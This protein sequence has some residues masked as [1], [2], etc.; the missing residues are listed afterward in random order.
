MILESSAVFMER[1][2]EKNWVSSVSAYLWPWGVK[3]VEEG[4]ED[5]WKEEEE[6]FDFI[7]G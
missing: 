1:I 6:V 4:Y 2:L 7:E 3:T 5:T